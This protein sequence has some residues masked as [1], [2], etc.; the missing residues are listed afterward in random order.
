MNEQGLERKHGMVSAGRVE[1]KTCVSWQF[2][3]IMVTFVILLRSAFSLPK[4]MHVVTHLFCLVV[5]SE[6]V[7][8]FRTTA[9]L[10]LLFVKPLACFWGGQKYILGDFRNMLKYIE[11][12]YCLWSGEAAIC[13][14]KSHFQDTGGAM[15]LLWAVKGLHF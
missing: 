2:N 8:I 4:H 6:F 15:V 1:T 3:N 12:I 11:N 9:C 13:E 14:P 7:E 10:S 5:S